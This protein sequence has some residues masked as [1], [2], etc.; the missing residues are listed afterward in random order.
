MCKWDVAILTLS[1]HYLN[2]KQV[3]TEILVSYQYLETY[4]P[5]NLSDHSYQDLKRISR[6][7]NRNQEMKQPLKK[8]KI[9]YYQSEL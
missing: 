9:I 6:E 5:L 4:F 7:G 2:T 8:M 1:G 3:E